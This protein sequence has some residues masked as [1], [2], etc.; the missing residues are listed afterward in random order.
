MTRDGQGRGRSARRP[1]LVSSRRAHGQSLDLRAYC[2]LCNAKIVGGLQIEP[3]L[4]AVAE[5]VAEAQGGVAGDRPLARD[6]LAD[7][8]R[9]HLKLTGKLGRRDADLLQFVR[10]DF[11]GVDGWSGHGLGLL[12]W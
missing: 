10:K 12:Q 9:R 5:P 1:R 2:R 4:G 6:D 11:A 3:E 7:A 8:V